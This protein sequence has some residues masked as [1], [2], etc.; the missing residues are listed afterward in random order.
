MPHGK[1]RKG[2]DKATVHFRSLQLGTTAGNIATIALAAQ[3]FSSVASIADS[4]AFYR[5]SKLKFRIIPISNGAG[6][7]ESTTVVYIGGITD[8]PP[9]THV[10][11]NSSLS[12]TFVGNTQ[13]VPSKWVDCSAELSGYQPWYKT[14]AGTTDPAEEV[15]GNLFVVTSTA[16]GNFTIEVVGTCVFRD[17]VS[18]AETPAERKARALVKERDRLLS[19]LGSTGVPS[20]SSTRAPMK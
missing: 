20:G 8:T 17:I 5:Y 10:V 9:A 19:V 11:A 3:S 18:T 13:F 14:I 16:T 2:G 15:Q 1:S 7:T 12:A 6:G 4:Y